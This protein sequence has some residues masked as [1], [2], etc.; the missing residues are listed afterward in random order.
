MT[1]P[2]NSAWRWLGISLGVAGA[3]AVT[4]NLGLN[5]AISPGNITAAWPPSGIALAAVLIFGKRVLPG[6]MLGSVLVN[7]TI[8]SGGPVHFPGSFNALGIPLALGLG[9]MM[10]ALLGATLIRPAVG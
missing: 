8:A 7:T 9:A 4:G 1:S 2:M 3:Y 10:Q 6:I 5:L